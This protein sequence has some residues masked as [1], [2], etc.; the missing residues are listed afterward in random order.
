MIR[1]SCSSCGKRYEQ[2]E[3]AAGKTGKCKC[4]ATV[5]IPAISSLDAP[6]APAPEVT[7]PPPPLPAAPAT[8]PCPFC[9]EPI[10]A[11]AKK[12]R[13]CGE[14]IDGKKGAT[15]PVAV[16]QSSTITTQRTGK[17][18][19]AA[20]LLGFL[21]LIVGVGMIVVGASAGPAASSQGAAEGVPTLP[22]GI[23]TFVGSLGT[24][25]AARVGAWWF[26]G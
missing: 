18:W 24:I 20:Q 25:I 12:C 16:R 22:L 21:G 26:H 4:G 3:S 10:Q 15:A 19:K 14:M 8:K 11:A 9:A 23:L 1:F 13:H 2:P 5:H 17:L 7:P 6:S